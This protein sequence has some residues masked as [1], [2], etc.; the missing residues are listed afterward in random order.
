MAELI[1]RIAAE[2]FPTRLA[3]PATDRDAPFQQVRWSVDDCPT[4][5]LPKVQPGEDRP[6]LPLA[7]LRHVS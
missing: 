7:A 5:Y 6:V 2:G 1:R 3:W 4:G